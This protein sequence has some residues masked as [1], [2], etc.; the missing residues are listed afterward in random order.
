[1][2]TQ[3]N[4]SLFWN[5]VKHVQTVL[6]CALLSSDMAPQ[7]SLKACLS[8]FLMNLEKAAQCISH[9]GIAV[10]SCRACRGGCCFLYL[11]LPAA[12][13]F[14]AWNSEA[15][16]MPVQSEGRPVVLG[17]RGSWQLRHSFLFPFCHLRSVCLS[18]LRQS[19]SLANF[20]P[21]P[22]QW[23]GMVLLGLRFVAWNGLG[24]S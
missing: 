13:Y 9:H 3:T 14:G 18:D 16:R 21:A 6:G 10:P 11:E 8:T 15:P 17:P 24:F 7:A 20:L 4:G 22:A 12:F 2:R 5:W 19:S 23:Q 1:M